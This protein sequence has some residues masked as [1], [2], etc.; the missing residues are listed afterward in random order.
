MCPF[1]ARGWRAGHLLTTDGSPMRSRP[2][3]PFVRAAVGLALG[4]ALGAFA[5]GCESFEIGARHATLTYTD[6]AR[7]AYEEAMSDF[8]DRDWEGARALFGEVR[9]LFPY[10]RF[11]RLAELRLADVDFEQEKF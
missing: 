5:V 9:R 10:T 2:A 11:A 1:A 3:P 6:D 7:A 4:L 8:R